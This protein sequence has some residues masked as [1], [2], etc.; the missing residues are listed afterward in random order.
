MYKWLKSLFKRKGGITV[1][2]KKV[3][4]TRTCVEERIGRQLSDEQY[5]RAVEASYKEDE[6]CRNLQE[7]INTIARCTR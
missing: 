1:K 4:Y 3:D 5:R 2:G 7:R 6:K